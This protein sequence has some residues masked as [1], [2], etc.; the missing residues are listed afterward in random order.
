M[1][2]KGRTEYEDVGQIL[3]SL[4]EK[5][6]VSVRQLAEAVGLHHTK[7]SRIETGTQPIDLIALI[8][9]ATDLGTTASEVLKLLESGKSGE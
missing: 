9:L 3:R 4:R 8:D 5:Q 1:R 6:G 2:S 7:L